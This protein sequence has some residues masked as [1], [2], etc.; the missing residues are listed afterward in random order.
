L[1]YV[2]RDELVALAQAERDADEIRAGR[3]ALARDWTLKS[4]PSAEIESRKEFPGPLIHDLP[5]IAQA[6]TARVVGDALMRE[7][8][9]TKALLHAEAELAD[10]PSDPPDLMADQDWLLRW[11]ECAGS[12]TVEEMQ[13]M[14]GQVLAGEIKAPGSFSLRTLELLRNLSRQEAE[15]IATVSKLA[16]NDALLRDVAV[17]QLEGVDLVLLLEMADLGLLSGVGAHLERRWGSSHKSDFLTL[18]TSH[19][20]CLKVTHADPARM[21]KLP[22]YLFT[23]VGREILRLGTYE[24]SER[25]LRSIGERLVRDG[26]DVE[27]GRC[28]HFDKD[29]TKFTEG[30]AIRLS[31]DASEKHPQ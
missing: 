10:D 6:T 20:R 30:Q 15:R 14:W 25:Y 2:R 16:V 28:T 19:G 27:L 29:R 18:L 13:H 23:N 7:V 8:N 5:S 17:L 26:Y 4:L 11:R 24:P 12:V 31:E 21:V 22:V 1:A 9:V 3:K